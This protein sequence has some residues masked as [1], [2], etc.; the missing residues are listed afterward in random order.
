[1]PDVLRSGRN[2]RGI[3]EWSAAFIL[4]RGLGRME[5]ASAGQKELIK[6]ASQ[7]YNAGQQLSSAEVQRL[8]YHYGPTQGYRAFY[9]RIAMMGRFE[10]M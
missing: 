1:M 10:E 9:T 5:R 7:I 3:G 2:I 6:A 4:V 8:L